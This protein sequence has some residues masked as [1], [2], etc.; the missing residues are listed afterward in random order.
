MRPCGST[1]RVPSAALIA[2]IL[3]ASLIE[4]SLTSELLRERACPSS[5]LSQELHLFE[6]AHTGAKSTGTAAHRLR[7][8]R[9]VGSPAAH[10]HLVRALRGGKGGKGGPLDTLLPDHGQQE[11]G[12]G[13]SFETEADSE[14][15]EEGDA[16]A[17]EADIP[18][19]A[20]PQTA[21]RMKASCPG[22]LRV[23]PPSPKAG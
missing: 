22:A 17:T 2:S 6:R 19:D 10:A 15:A 23:S 11:E 18:R 20:V 9:P 12:N 4:A 1:C 3:A 8:S 13:G 14:D 21:G 16:S 7:V 5:L